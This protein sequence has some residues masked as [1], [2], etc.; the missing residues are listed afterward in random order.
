MSNKKKVELSVEQMARNEAIFRRLEED[1]S[2]LIEE[3]RAMQDDLST[4]KRRRR[5]R[6]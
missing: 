4:Q 1:K 6:S 5:R 3:T 2:R